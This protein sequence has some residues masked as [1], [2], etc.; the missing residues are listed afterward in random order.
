MIQ[1]LGIN[2]VVGYSGSIVTVPGN[3]V[4]SGTT[5]VNG[6]DSAGNI[7]ATNGNIVSTLGHVKGVHVIT[8]G[9]TEMSTFAGPI[10]VSNTSLTSYLNGP[11][12]VKSLAS[13][14]SLSG[15]SLSCGGKIS[16][17]YSTTPTFVSG[18][19]GHI[20][21]TVMTGGLL[22]SSSTD[23]LS[24]TIGVWLIN[25]S[26]RAN[27][28]QLPASSVSLTTGSATDGIET[29]S[30]GPVT[31]STTQSGFDLQTVRRF[32]VATTA[33]LITARS[34][35]CNFTNFGEFKAVRLA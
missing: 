5:N 34:P 20:V 10:T 35:A 29:N 2:I 21:S 31:F 26:L 24:L 13:T 16:L 22:V 17:T 8:T 27:N 15:S 3:F 23:T 12:D 30:I 28:V 32:T 7:E 19:I 11:V 6:L 18:D 14:G 1:F 4:V 9:G 33:T 25:V